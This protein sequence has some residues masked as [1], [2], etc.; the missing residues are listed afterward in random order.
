MYK[1]SHFSADS[2]SAFILEIKITSGCETEAD[3]LLSLE[4]GLATFD[5]AV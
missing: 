4:R 2:S 3:I 1:A 5:L